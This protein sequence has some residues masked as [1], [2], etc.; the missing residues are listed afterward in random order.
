[1]DDAYPGCED[2]WFYVDDSVPDGS[3][4]VCGRYNMPGLSDVVY[5]GLSSVDPAE[6][7]ACNTVVSEACATIGFP[8]PECTVDAD[9]YPI[10]CSRCEDG[11]CWD[12]I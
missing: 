3:G 12:C 7:R 9:C 10:D 5:E 11:H 1:M 8:L 4:G 6:V 2:F